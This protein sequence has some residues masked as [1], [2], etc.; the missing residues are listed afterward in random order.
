MLVLSNLIATLSVGEIILMVKSMFLPGLLELLVFLLDL[1]ILVLSNQIKQ[2]SV[3][4]IIDGV[5]R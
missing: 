3:G 2:W 1:T 4:V 5:N